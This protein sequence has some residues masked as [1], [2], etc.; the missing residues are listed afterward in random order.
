MQSAR[1]RRR[2]GLCV[3]NWRRHRVRR[4]LCVYNGRRDH[5]LRGLCVYN[6]RRTSFRAKCGITTGAVKASAARCAII[7]SPDRIL[8]RADGQARRRGEVVNA[9]EYLAN[10]WFSSAEAGRAVSLRWRVCHRPHVP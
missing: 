3:Y 8:A 2:R 9:E 4:Q 6:W 10:A 7:A 5:V 1:S